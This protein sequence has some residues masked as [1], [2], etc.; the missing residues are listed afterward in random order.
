MNIPFSPPFI[1]QS[2]VDQVLDTLNNKWITTGPKV[3]ALEQEVKVITGTDEVICVN[4]WTSGAI[5]MLK[6][7]GV[8]AGDEVIVPAYTY[9]ATALAVLHCGA[10]PVMVDVLEDFNIDPEKVRAA[11][12][13]RTKA[14]IAVDIAG[15][16]CDY[17][18]LKA[19]ISD[20]RIQK[21]FRCAS[22]KQSLLNRILLISDAAHSIGST[23]L[24]KPA[25]QNCDVTIFSF[26]AVKNITT[27][28][29][30]AICLNLPTQFDHE[31]EYAY[32]KMYTLNG[33]NKDALSKSRGAGW[34]YDIL[35]QGLKINMPD[36]C[37]AIGLAQLRKYDNDLLPQRK[38]IAKK[39]FEGFQDQDWFISPPLVST[40]RESCYH[41]F[42]LRVKGLSEEQRD[43]IIDDLAALGIATNVHFIPMPMLTLF[44]NM[45]Y[46]IEDYPMAYQ[47]YACEIS[48]P[49]YPQLTQSEIDFII[50]SVISCVQIQ[51]NRNI[52]VIETNVVELKQM[53]VAS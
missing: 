4:S 41:L 50:P 28:E 35:F 31:A 44:K 23:Y 12:T 49:I 46:K 30:G 1:D 25:A 11:I 43:Q 48:L 19:V 47:N 33:Q 53:A 37:A 17:A 27:A 51:L 2:V 18:A 40:Q 21:K 52:K 26:H 5:L 20:P 16:P 14:I 39:Y 8:K 15:W 42:P 7:F 32:L 38:A 3:K 24:N 9:S 36:I 34:R 13:S 45:G 29:G 22:D 10:T 6:W